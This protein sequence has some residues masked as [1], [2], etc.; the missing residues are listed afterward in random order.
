MDNAVLPPMRKKSRVAPERSETGSSPTSSPEV[1]AESAESPQTRT[2][3]WP[4]SRTG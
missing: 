1:W 2:P 4:G 3:D